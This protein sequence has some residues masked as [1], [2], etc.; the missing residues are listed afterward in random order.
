MLL[1]GPAAY[2]LAATPL[3]LLAAAFALEFLFGEARGPLARLPHPVRLIGRAVDILENKLN[4][5][6]RSPTDLRVR[7]LAVALIVPASAAAVGYAI[8]MAARALPYGWIIELIAVVPMLAQRNLYRYVAAVAIGLS[9]QGVEGGRRAVAHIV[10]RDVT[11]L[12]AHGVARAAIE[13]CAEN[14]SDAVV[15]PALWYVAL[16]LPGLYLYK[17]VN[18][19]D[20]MI[21]HRSPRYIDFGM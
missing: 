6:Q 11:T 17:T 3:L 20:S 10:G 1:I 21:G 16:G 13:S 12:D 8:A 15:A 14:F 7:G 19:L 18:T 5:P 4:R 2:G 9:Q